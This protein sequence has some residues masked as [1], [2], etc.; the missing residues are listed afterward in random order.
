MHAPDW[1]ELFLALSG[2]GE[3]PDRDHEPEGLS[4]AQLLARL[5]G[6]EDRDEA[7]ALLMRLV[8]LRL[9]AHDPPEEG[10]ASD[11]GHGGD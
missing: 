10:E 7:R 4:E 8:V 3:P 9:T 6:T 5:D 1:V 2:K 11:R